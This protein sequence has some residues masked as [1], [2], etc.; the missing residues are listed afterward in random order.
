MVLV[1]IWGIGG[2]VI[3]N[4]AGLRSVPTELYDAAKIDGAGW[5]GQMRH[6]TLPLMSPVIF[7]SLTLG[8]VGGPA[9]LPRPVRAQER[10][11]RAGWH[12]L[13]LQPLHL[14]E[15]LHVPAHVVRRDAGVAAVRDHAGPDRWPCS[16]RRGAGSTTRGALIV[17]APISRSRIRT[18]RHG[19][20]DRVASA[21]DPGA[22][23]AQWRAVV[24]ADADRRLPGGGVSVAPAPIGVVLAQVARADHRSWA[25]RSGRPTRSTFDYKGRTLNVYEVPIDGTTRSLALLTP[26]RTSSAF[27]DPANPDARPITWQGSWRVARRAWTFAAAP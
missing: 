20:P 15:L 26:G 16:P 6:V 19:P 4:L 22:T 13:L 11:R 10:H 2:A 8:V 21:R 14:Q 1:G 5:R 17:A 3:I 24:P 18:A 7:Y 23:L 12:D 9:V 25:R 27:V